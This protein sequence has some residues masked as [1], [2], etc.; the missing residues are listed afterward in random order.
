M[1]V[2]EYG[3]LDYVVLVVPFYPRCRDFYASLMGS[4]M[5]GRI[6]SEYFLLD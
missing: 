3:L 4:E 5:N 6:F 1:D 2:C